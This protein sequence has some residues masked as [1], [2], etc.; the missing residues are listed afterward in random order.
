M[1]WWPLQN[2]HKEVQHAQFCNICL[3]NLFTTVFSVLRHV[4]DCIAFLLLCHWVRGR[5]LMSLSPSHWVTDDC[6][7]F[8]LSCL[9]IPDRYIMFVS[10]Y[11]GVTDDCIVFLLP[12]HWVRDRY[13]MYVSPSHRV[14]NDCITFLLPCHWV[15]DRYIMSISIIYLKEVEKP[16]LANLFT[17]CFH[18]AMSNRP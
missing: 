4:D 12:C 16:D 15:R 17:Y 11:H 10:P 1:A 5:Y 3:L 18:V 7:M 2:N 13:I 8:L 9:L 14:T 6:I